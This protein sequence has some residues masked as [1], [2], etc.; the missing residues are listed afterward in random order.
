MFAKWIEHLRGKK[1]WIMGCGGGYD[2]FTGLPIYFELEKQGIEV[3][4]GNFSLTKDELIQKGEKI[5]E[6]CYL[7]TKEYR[8]DGDISYF[9][10]YYLMKQLQRPIYTIYHQGN[11]GDLEKTYKKIIEKEKVKVVILV[12]GGCDSLMFGKEKELATPVEDMMNI[13]VVSQLNLNNIISESYLLCL[14]LTADCHHGITLDDIW[15]NI[16]LLTSN[17]GFL[18]SCSLSLSDLSVQLYSSIFSQ[19]HPSHSIVNCS[20]ISSLEGHYGNFHHPMLNNRLSNQLLD[21]N[22]LLSMYFLF[23]LPILSNHIEYL[24]GFSRE[25]DS[26]QIDSYISTWHSNL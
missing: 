19:C 10:E 15:K 16:S 4:L 2:I 25:F 3:I 17:G 5:E 24:S 26:D 20:I 23:N 13:F 11:L 12:D 8:L 18:G 9:P 7:V 1:V 14:G 22:P 6:N 21:I